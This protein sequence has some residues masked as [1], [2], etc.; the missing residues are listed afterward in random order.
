MSKS[1]LWRVEGDQVFLTPHPGQSR[2]W[3]SDRRCVF[4][5]AGSQSGKTSFGPWWLWR[6]VERNGPGDY[7][8]ATATYD[9]F[10]LK[11]L[12]E[13]LTIFCDT[14]GW[15][16][17][18]P[19]DRIIYST[20]GKSR[21]ILRS[22]NVPGGLES[23]TAKAAWLDECGQDN[24]RLESW[25]AVQRRLALC[26][27]RILGTTTTYNLGWLWTEV[28]QKWR[29]GDPDFDI[30]QFASTMNPVY[31]KA[32][33]ERARRMLP[34]WKFE[35]FYLGIFTRPAGLIYE[36]FDEQVHLVEPFAIPVEWPRYVGVDFGAVHTALVW[37]AEDVEHGAYY[38]YRESLEG[39]KTTAEHARAAL[40]HAHNERVV[41]WFGGAAS[42]QQERWDWTAAGVPV[43]RPPID[44]VE[45]GIDRVIWLLKEKRLF[46]F[47]TCAGLRDELGTYSRELDERGDA[48]EKIKDKNDFHRLDALRY[49]VAGLSG[50]K[51]GVRWLD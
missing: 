10:K 18:K 7:L 30:I 44:S 35:M 5:I 47:S 43:G 28:Y 42:E 3:S 20:D 25:E 4:I 51:V 9:L 41:A 24:F 46:F 29:R 36:D 48:T 34:R 1:V 45:A 26:Q 40:A 15:G 37:I 2:A 8:A 14:L 32:E 12:P 13:M 11:M 27:G 6:E 33:F 39:N 21:I 23:A 17:Y 22:A 16:Y 49:C 19:S 31:P 38:V 50:P